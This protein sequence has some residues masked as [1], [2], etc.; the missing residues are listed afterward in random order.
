[1]QTE[2]NVEHAAL[3]TKKRFSKIKNLAKNQEYK[4]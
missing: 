3:T 2:S 4:D 1:M